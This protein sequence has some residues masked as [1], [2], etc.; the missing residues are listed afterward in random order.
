MICL[1]PW[2]CVCKVPQ[3]S[4]PRTSA[5]GPAPRK[6]EGVGRG[7]CRRRCATGDQ[8]NPTWRPDPASRNDRCWCLARQ[9][10][11]A[12][13][14]DITL[15]IAIP[16]L[17]VFVVQELEGL[18]GADLKQLAIADQVLSVGLREFLLRVVKASLRHSGCELGPAGCRWVSTIALYSVP[19]ESASR[20][21]DV[22]PFSPRIGCTTFIS[23][24]S[25]TPGRLIEV[26]SAVY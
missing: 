16:D 7:N 21:I 26:S 13:L 3:V 17:Q 11:E 1:D 24:S 15:G 22:A 18:A 14:P 2:L 8:S 20:P 4:G 10:G 9:N 12:S 25:R 5:S 19:G 6:L 23:I